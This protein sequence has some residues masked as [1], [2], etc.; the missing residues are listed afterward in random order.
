M[1]VKFSL[2]ELVFLASGLKISNLYGFEYDNSEENI[3][4]GETEVK[5][6]KKSLEDKGYIK[7]I[8]NTEI[9]I[10]EY[11]YLVIKVWG[12]PKYAVTNFNENNGDIIPKEFI[13]I[14]GEALV[15]MKKSMGIYEITL[16][17]G[18]ENIEDFLAKYLNLKEGMDL[19]N[20]YNIVLSENKL[21]SILENF[22]KNNIEKLENQI[23]RMG[24]TNEEGYKMLEK[25]NEGGEAFLS[26]DDIKGNKGA[27][28]KLVMIGDGQYIFK[29]I[30]SRGRNK[31]VI[32]KQSLK[33]ALNTI[34][35]I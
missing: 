2:D 12:E 35:I 22:N 29:N 14:K 19:Q 1:K 4:L 7:I 31:V 16:I 33:E 15:T 18:K 20:S 8:N 21:E 5:S 30:K 17:E 11:I 34:F 6:A 23:N 9:D 27:L 25:I 28:I 32:A 26:I 3:N 10:E 13:F 24:L